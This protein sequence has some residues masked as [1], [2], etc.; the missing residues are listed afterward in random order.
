M[1][2]LRDNQGRDSKEALTAAL[3]GLERAKERSLDVSEIADALKD[4]RV[5]NHF[6]DRMRVIMGGINDGHIYPQ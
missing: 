3:E 1:R 4:L 5:R 2:F 6:A